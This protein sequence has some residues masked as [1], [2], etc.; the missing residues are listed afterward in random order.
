MKDGQERL[1]RGA[2]AA[3]KIEER[4]R[5]LA[6]QARAAADEACKSGLLDLSADLRD[7]GARFEQAAAS[8]ALGY[9]IGRRI[10]ADI[11]GQ[12]EIVAFSGKD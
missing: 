6:A 8:M 7:M 3:R 2:E 1:D 9:A 12:G 5:T 4:A 10:K 11:P